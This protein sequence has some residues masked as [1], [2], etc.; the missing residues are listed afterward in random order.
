MASI[1]ENLKKANVVLPK[2]S[3][4][5]A[6]YVSTAISGNL[7]YISGQ[8][9]MKDG[10][11]EYQGKLGKDVSN[12]D[13]YEAARLCGLNLLA[14]AEA[15]IGSLE[16]IKRC[17]QLNIFINST[18]EFVEQPKIANGASDLMVQILEEKG[19]HTRAAV[20]S[21]SLPLNSA[22][23]VAGIFEITQ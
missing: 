4:P 7:L 6:N 18:P 15:A 11:L 9:C 20:S 10:K 22:V 21:I 1:T 16:K 14:Q 19:K 17:I 12:E 2:V 3:A 8:I 5:V 13:G 23:E